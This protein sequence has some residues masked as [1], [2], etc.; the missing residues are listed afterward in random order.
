MGMNADSAATLVLTISNAIRSDGFMPLLSPH[1]E[2][3]D[4]YRDFAAALSGT[5]TGA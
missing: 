2:C 5:V 3:P 1:P 4:D